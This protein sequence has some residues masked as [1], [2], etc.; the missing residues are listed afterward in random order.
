VTTAHTPVVTLAQVKA[1]LRVIHTG[2]DALLADLIAQAEDEAL[3]FLNRTEAPTLP[4][5][6]PSEYDSSSSELPEEVP[7]S[8]DPPAPSY[9]KAVCILVQAAY[10]AADPEKQAKLRANAETVLYPYRTKLGV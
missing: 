3:R 5:D 8:E 2:D 4:V 1:W 10:E 6:Y 9:V 7:S